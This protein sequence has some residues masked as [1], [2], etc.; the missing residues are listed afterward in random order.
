MAAGSRRRGEN[1]FTWMRV[2]YVIQAPLPQHQRGRASRRS[3][4][5]NYLLIISKLLEEMD[6]L[7]ERARSLSDVYI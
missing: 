1:C 2:Y 7:R 4:D 6:H 3:C 5:L